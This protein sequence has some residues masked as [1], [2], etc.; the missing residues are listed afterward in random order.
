M[1][2]AKQKKH[3]Q[4]IRIEEL[5]IWTYEKQKADIIEDRG[6]GL[7]PH[8]KDA[9][10]IFYRMISGDGAYQIHRN[11]ELGIKLEITGW[12][13]AQI[14]PDAELIHD[15]IKSKK[16]THLERGLLIDFGKTGL[17]PDWMPDAKPQ[18]SAART[19]KGNIKMIYSDSKRTRPIAC[20]LDIVL[21]QG[22]IDFKRK[23]YNDW[24]QALDKL[25][26]ELWRADDLVT[27]FNVQ[28]PLAK[29]SP[30]L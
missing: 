26:T 4:D 15:L 17:M 23:T 18:I 5:V 28:P 30:W 12:P 8:E 19:R 10:G 7:M 22:H 29:Q 13:T 3:R 2:A 14:H 1:E 11:W 6:V 9:D 24:W 25:K 20:V 21:S 16:F 27:S